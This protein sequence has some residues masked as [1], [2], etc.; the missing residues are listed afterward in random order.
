MRPMAQS[1]RKDEEDAASKRRLKL[2]GRREAP[3]A[4]HHRV[5]R[6]DECR[7]PAVEPQTPPARGAVRREEIVALLATRR[8]GARADDAETV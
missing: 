6:P 1:A 5:L 4:R 2:L 8:L 3:A 7:L